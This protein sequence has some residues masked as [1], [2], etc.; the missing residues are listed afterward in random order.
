MREVEYWMP[1]GS[2]LA[3]GSDHHAGVVSW[4]LSPRATP[5]HS[6]TNDCGSGQVYYGIF[7]LASATGRKKPYPL[8]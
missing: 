1:V 4:L 7:G 3:F 5:E 2:L 6:V 8:W